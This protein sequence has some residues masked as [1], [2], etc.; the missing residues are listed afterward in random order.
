[1]NVIELNVLHAL[2]KYD[3]NVWSLK[4]EFGIT[5]EQV[6]KLVKKGL[7]TLFQG[8]G[9]CGGIRNLSL[10]LKGK[11]FIR[12]YCSTCECMPCDCNWGHN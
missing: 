4:D 5:E 2:Q 3:R 11:E 1:M 8:E 7:V 9:F 12:S 6:S 10:T